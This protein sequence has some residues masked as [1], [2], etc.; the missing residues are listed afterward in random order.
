MNTLDNAATQTP[1]HK[2]RNTNAATQPAHN[3]GS[4]TVRSHLTHCST[5][6]SPPREVGVGVATVV[7][8]LFTIVNSEL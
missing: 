2:R 6:P 1:Q 5:L 3:L 8:E 7:S 4:T